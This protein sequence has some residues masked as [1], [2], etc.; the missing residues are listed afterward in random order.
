ML[1]LFVFLLSGEARRRSRARPSHD[2]AKG[3]SAFMSEQEYASEEQ[4]KSKWIW[5]KANLAIQHVSQGVFT[6]LDLSRPISSMSR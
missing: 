1:R 2:S 6:K 5:L 3:T 4:R